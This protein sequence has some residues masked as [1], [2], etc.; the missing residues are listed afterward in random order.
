MLGTPGL[1]ATTSCLQR[2]SLSSLQ[3]LVDDKG[4]EGEHADAATN[5]IE[6]ADDKTE[7]AATRLNFPMSSAGNT[8]QDTLSIIC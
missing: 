6:E 3:V 8:S 2:A 5:A 1:F 7:T 4:E